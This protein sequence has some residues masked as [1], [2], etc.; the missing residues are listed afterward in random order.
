[1]LH[2]V[3]FPVAD[4][5]KSATLYDAALSVLGYRRVHDDGDFI[6]YGVEDGKDQF[7]IAEV[8]P[9]QIAGP[10]FHLAFAAATRDAVDEFYKA[11]MAHGAT[12]NGPP[13]LRAHYGPDYYAAFV[14]DLDGHHIEAV[15]NEPVD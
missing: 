3:S 9:T 15:I 14:I 12:D 1:M 6:G 7:A 8:K 11:A 5:M 4:L 2:H 13:G 10:G